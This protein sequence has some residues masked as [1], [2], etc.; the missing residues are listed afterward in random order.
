[1]EWWPINLKLGLYNFFHAL[2]LK[3]IIIEELKLELLLYFNG[4]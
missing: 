2:A 4:F 3:L 1:M